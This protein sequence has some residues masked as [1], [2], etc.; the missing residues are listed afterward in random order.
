MSGPRLSLQCRW[1]D[2]GVVVIDATGEFDAEGAPLLCRPVLRFVDA[3]QSRFVVDLK[4]VGGVD[5]AAARDLGGL[6][7]RIRSRGG[8]L[9]VTAGAKVRAALSGAGVAHDGL[10]FDTV[11][12]AVEA[13]RPGITT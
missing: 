5:S 4:K 7:A 12:E 11:A 9:A 1:D 10:V 13:C 6:A 3:G 2:E 8:T